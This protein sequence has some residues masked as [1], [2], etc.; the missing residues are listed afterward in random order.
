MSAIKVSKFQLCV[1]Y[2]HC[3][4]LLR[5]QHNMCT[6]VLSLLYASQMLFC[7]LQVVS[8]RASK[9]VGPFKEAVVFMIGG[10]NYLEHESLSLYAS[11][12]QPPKNILYGATDIIS[13]EAFAKQLA[14]LGKRAGGL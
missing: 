5:W 1:S 4:V 7:L 11:K 12:S 2:T 13:P 8:G 14:D 6:L 3:E 9:A 10:G